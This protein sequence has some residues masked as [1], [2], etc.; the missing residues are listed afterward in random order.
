MLP[1]PLN[2]LLRRLPKN[3]LV[4]YSEDSEQTSDGSVEYL[5]GH[6]RVSPL[7]Q[8][9]GTEQVYEIFS[10]LGELV[11]IVIQEDRGRRSALVRFRTESEAREAVRM[12]DGGSIDMQE[13]LVS[14]VSE[15]RGQDRQKCIN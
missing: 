3:C 14:L 7:T 1:R 13:V 4:D 5:A 10:T 11:D 15:E 2:S 12:M 9:V 8:R 6:V